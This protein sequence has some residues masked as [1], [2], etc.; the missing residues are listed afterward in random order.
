MLL[1]SQLTIGSV[2]SV[3]RCVSKK[4]LHIVWENKVLII[5]RF[6]LLYLQERRGGRGGGRRSGG[7]RDRGGRSGGVEEGGVEEEG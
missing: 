4:W 2:V 1:L 7:R 6:W 3:E 5:L